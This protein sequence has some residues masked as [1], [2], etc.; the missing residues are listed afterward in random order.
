MVTFYSSNFYATGYIAGTLQK[1]DSRLGQSWIVFDLVDGE[2]FQVSTFDNTGKSG[3]LLRKTAWQ[4]KK[5][6]K[7]IPATL[8]SVWFP[9]VD[10]LRNFS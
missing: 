2:C 6:P 7:L 3:L 10:N 4:K 8:N 5:L 1:Y 9:T